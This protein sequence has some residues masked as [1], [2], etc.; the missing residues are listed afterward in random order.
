MIQIKLPRVHLQQVP[1]LQLVP[2]RSTIGR[3]IWYCIFI[4]VIEMP[5]MIWSCSKLMSPSIYPNP[6]LHYLCFISQIFIINEH[7]CQ[8]TAKLGWH[9]KII[10]I[11][12]I[13]L[14]QRCTCFCHCHQNCK[15][16]DRL[17][18]ILKVSNIGMA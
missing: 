15:H 11:H 9:L 12:H 6:L 18:I 10:L 1:F 13:F 8:L 3:H 5:C 2:W 7:P 16:I 14:P 17:L 4:F